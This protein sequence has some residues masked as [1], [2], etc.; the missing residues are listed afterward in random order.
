[1]KSIPAIFLLMMFCGLVNATT[2]TWSPT[3]SHVWANASNWTPNDDYPK[4]LSDTAIFSTA[5]RCSSSVTISIKTLIINS[6]D[7]LFFTANYLTMEGS[8]PLCKI[9]S[10][11]QLYIKLATNIWTM[12]ATESGSIYSVDANA[13]SPS[14]IG[15]SS[16]VW[17]VSKSSVPNLT[18]TLPAITT[19]GLNMQWYGNPSSGTTNFIMSGNINQS[20]DNDAAL[21]I[22]SS[23]NCKTFFNISGYTLTTK[24]LKWGANQATST[25]SLLVSGSTINCYDVSNV[26]HTGTTKIN[27]I[28]SNIL[29]AHDVTLDPSWQITGTGYKIE[30][31]G[32]PSTLT[33]VGKSLDIVAVKSGKRLILSDSL[34]CNTL[35]DSG[36]IFGSTKNVYTKNVYIVNTV[37]SDT[38]N[39]VGSILN[40]TGD[41]AVFF[42]RSISPSFLGTI[43]AKNIVFDIGRNMYCKRLDITSGSFVKASGNVTIEDSTYTDGDLDSTMWTTGYER[44]Q[45]KLSLPINTSII[46]T[47]FTNI[48]SINLL[49]DTSQTG[50]NLGNNSGIVFKRSSGVYDTTPHSITITSCSFPYI[51]RY[52]TLTGTGFTDD[53]SIKI[54]TL[55]WQPATYISSTK[56]KFYMPFLDQKTHLL[57]VKNKYGGLGWYILSFDNMSAIS[58]PMHFG[59][60]L[61]GWFIVGQHTGSSITASVEVG[62]TCAKVSDPSKFTEGMLLIYGMYNGDSS[63]YFTKCKQIRNDTIFISNKFKKSLLS[64]SMIESFHNTGD[65]IH[66]SLNGMKAIVQYG[67]R[68][69][70]IPG[71]SRTLSRIKILNRIDTLANKNISSTITADSSRNQF[72]PSAIKW[73]SLKVI[74]DGIRQGISIP[75]GSITPGEYRLQV[76]GSWGVRKDSIFIRVHS[77]VTLSLDTI[78]VEG[79]MEVN[80]L[81]F[82][83][84]TTSVDSLELLSSGPN[85]FYISHIEVFTLG[86]DCPMGYGR[87]SWF[88]DSWTSQG[89]DSTGGKREFIKKLGFEYAFCHGHGGATTVTLQADWADSNKQYSPFWWWCVDGTND[90]I[91]TRTTA[92]Y[93]QGMQW[94]IDSAVACG[95]KPIL[96]DCAVCPVVYPGRIDYQGTDSSVGF[97][98]SANLYRENDKTDDYVID[99]PVIIDS[100]RPH[101]KRDPILRSARRLDTIT[102]YL[103]TNIGDSSALGKIYLGRDTTGSM[104]IT[105]WFNTAGRDSIWAIVPVNA[106]LNVNYRPLVVSGVGIYSLVRTPVTWREPWILN[107][108]GQVR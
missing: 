74:T 64:G 21:I 20:G 86:R 42:S 89:D 97:V 84:S 51:N 87:A 88:G 92:A 68:Y 55:P 9:G 85:T 70:Q 36:S 16:M 75:I 28:N 39:L 18:I 61:H 5:S 24:F 35:L 104:K 72:I 49:F 83:N 19:S 80:N 10:G 100:I 30:F 93:T 82:N 12:T 44:P 48:R 27:L 23:A 71:V 40:F 2:R 60:M 58:I 14:I 37:A 67:H 59:A 1:M 15:N 81:L 76:T 69:L 95:M 22:S 8:G 57:T 54:D 73:P 108:K 63:T 79:D 17:M 98:K 56:T 53:D 11:G 105:R 41:T 32:T 25:C 31:L 34:T 78:L 46:G 102:I 91:A 38:T 29:A 50:L 66:G 26:Y 94:L 77:G 103:T 45:A 7:S 52:D 101:T 43:K 107:V 4:T 13:L 33:S 90:A 47:K 106:T 65:P 3:I 6:T 96:F 62:D 99:T